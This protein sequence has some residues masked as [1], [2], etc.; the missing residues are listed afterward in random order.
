[1]IREKLE[2]LIENRKLIRRSV[3]L[4]ITVL[5][6]VYAAMGVWILTQR[7]QGHITT[8]ELA[9]IIG[10][11]GVNGFLFKSYQNSRDKEGK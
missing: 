3:F 10:F 2:H 6:G 4:F 11:A 9:L 7:P 1:M 5:C 8:E